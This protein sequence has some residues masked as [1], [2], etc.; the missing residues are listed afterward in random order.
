MEGT[1]RVEGGD[2]EAPVR[3][4]PEVHWGSCGRKE[5]VCQES[6]GGVEC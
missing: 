2:G 6:R 4:A 5:G 1:E 3:C